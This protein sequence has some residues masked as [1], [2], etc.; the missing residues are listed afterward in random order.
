MFGLFKKKKKKDANSLMLADLNGEP[1][2]EGDLVESL[3]YE[4]GRSKIIIGEGGQLLYESVE[5]G[6]QV[7]WALMVDAATNLQKVRKI[8]GN[9]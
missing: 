4:L 1:L 6:K 7:S 5:T 3:R 2:K 8:Q 9:D